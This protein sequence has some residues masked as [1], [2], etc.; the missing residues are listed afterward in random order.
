VEN[1]RDFNNVSNEFKKYYQLRIN[2]ASGIKGDILAVSHRILNSLKK[3]FV[4]Y[5]MSVVLMNLERQQYQK[6]LY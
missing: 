4:I 2:L 3:S 1:I 6:M 5:L